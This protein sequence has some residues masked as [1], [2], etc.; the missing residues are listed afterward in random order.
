MTDTKLKPGVTLALVAHNEGHT[1]HQWFEHMLPWV[2]ECVVVDS[3]STD[4]TAAIARDYADRVETVP[5]RLN[6]D[7]NKNHAF[8][9]GTHEWVLSLDTDEYPDE[10]LLKHIQSVSRS[11]DTPHAGYEIQ[12]RHFALRQEILRSS[13]HLRLFRTGRG[14]FPGESVHQVIRVHGSVGRLDGIV[15]HYSYDR[16]FDRMHKTNLYSETMAAHWYHSGKPFRVREMLYK[17][18]VHFIKHYFRH[19]GYRK[20]MLGFFSAVDGS[21]S[22]MMRYIKLWSAYKLGSFPTVSDE[23]D[24]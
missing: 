2:D 11:V 24:S 10:I 6:F 3:G 23:I 13:W 5:N 7:I 8:T 19:G 12:M 22:V 9:L 15:N 16:I 18:L 1:L 14:Q 21:Y 17:T 20:G 4:E